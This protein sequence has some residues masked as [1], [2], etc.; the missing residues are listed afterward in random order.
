MS[1]VKLL[2][3]Q[4]LPLLLQLGAV[5][6]T[7]SMSKDQ[8]RCPLHR[9]GSWPSEMFAHLPTSNTPDTG[10]SREGSRAAEEQPAGAC[11]LMPPS[12]VQMMPFSPNQKRRQEL[13]GASERGCM[14]SGMQNPSLQFAAEIST[15]LR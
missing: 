1:Y 13:P 7:P 2:L 9:D 3:L 11:Q 14:Q 6:Q 15:R 5:L 4:L 10:P 8:G 12:V